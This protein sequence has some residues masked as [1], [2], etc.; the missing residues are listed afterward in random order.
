[1]ANQTRAQQAQARLLEVKAS[2]GGK[3]KYA[4][5][6]GEAV[7]RVAGLLKAGKTITGS[8]KEVAAWVNEQVKGSKCHYVS[9]QKWARKGRGDRQDPGR[10]H[11]QGKGELKDLHRRRPR[12]G[13]RPA[14]RGQGLCRDSRGHRLHGGDG[15]DLVQQLRERGGRGR[16]VALK[17]GSRAAY[18]ALTRTRQT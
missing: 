12:E 17:A 16:R 18:P 11:F 10:P 9:V 5:V 8:A 15:G 4:L 6:K 14:H 3:D 2:K 13:H 1:M 7:T